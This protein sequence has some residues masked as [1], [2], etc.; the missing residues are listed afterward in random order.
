MWKLKSSQVE[1]LQHKIY[2]LNELIEREM[3][4]LSDQVKNGVHKQI[5]LE[6]QDISSHLNYVFLSEDSTKSAIIRN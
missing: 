2:D 1:K 4:T 3:H 5:M 6:L